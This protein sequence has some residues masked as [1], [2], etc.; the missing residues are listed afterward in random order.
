[1]HAVEQFKLIKEEKNIG[2]IAV[3]KLL[4]PRH[5]LVSLESFNQSN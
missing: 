1:M 2:I 4:S 5:Q 3:L